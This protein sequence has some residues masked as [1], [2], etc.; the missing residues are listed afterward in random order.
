MIKQNKN[1]KKQHW[2]PQFYLRCFSDAHGG[3]HA[4][5][6]QSD[7]FYPT[8]TRDT[9]SSNYLYEVP[10][11]QKHSEDGTRF[12]QLN[13]IENQLSRTE[14]LLAQSYSKLIHSCEHGKLEGEDFEDGRLSACY[15]FA[16]MTERHPL[17]IEDRRTSAAKIAR[18]YLE[19]GQ[20]TTKE[21]ERL[22]AHGMEGEL[23]GLAE[24]FAMEA[25]FSS[26]RKVAQKRV[27]SELCG[28]RL[29][30]VE[31][32]TGIEF[33]ST[34]L[35]LYFVGDQVSEFRFDVAYLPLSGRY[36]CFFVGERG[37][38]ARHT[39]TYAEVRRCNLNL[40][41]AHSVWDIAYAKSQ[42]SLEVSVRD[43]RIGKSW[44]P[45]ETI[46]S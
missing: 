16:C 33:V 24:H 1:T 34:S 5:N 41:T 12:L 21:A 39:A 9:C 7:K 20:L 38:A 26:E 27:Y 35:P 32:P 40:L 25:A 3:L 22:K 8:N 45:Q 23:E 44:L 10:R 18:D 28:K 2:I 15:L 4:Y 31:A 37:K 36:A 19:S 29:V 43:W 42:G 17:A 11:S 13:R 14:H 46:H 30:I 6:S